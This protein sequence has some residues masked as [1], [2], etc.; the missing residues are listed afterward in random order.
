[1]KATCNPGGAGH[2]WVK[3][4]YRLDT[5]P[6]GFEVFEYTFTNPF[7]K[8]EKITKTRCFIPSKVSENKY[9]GA[10]YIGNL[11]SVGLGHAGARMAGRRL[12]GY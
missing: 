9:L 2:H 1:M 12:V 5:H 6:K 7:N 11:F 4:R 10:D 8:N 3:Q